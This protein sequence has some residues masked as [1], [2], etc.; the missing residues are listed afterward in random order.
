MP[1]GA[2][3][4]TVQYFAPRRRRRPNA[5]SVTLARS[6]QSIAIR[7]GRPSVDECA[8]TM[9]SLSRCTDKSILELDGKGSLRCNC[10]RTY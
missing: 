6:R 9:P 1:Y 8:A 3:P 5:R 7:S 2:L 10:G 4:P